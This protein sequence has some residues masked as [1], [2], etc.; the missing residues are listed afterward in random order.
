MVICDYCGGGVCCGLD[1]DAPAFASEDDGLVGRLWSARPREVLHERG[2]FRVVGLYVSHCCVARLLLDGKGGEEFAVR[3]RVHDCPA[4]GGD[5]AENGE[6]DSEG[7]E[8]F[9][10]QCFHRE[11]LFVV[12]AY[13][14][15]L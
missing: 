4:Y 9:M 1:S 3:V 7:F 5:A 15:M 8:F 10:R 11:Q 13:S 6:H 14:A 12:V 2:G